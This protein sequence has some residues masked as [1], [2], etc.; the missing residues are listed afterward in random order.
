VLAGLAAG[1]GLGLILRRSPPPVFVRDL[2]PTAAVNWPLPRDPWG[3]TIRNPYHVIS[4]NGEESPHGIGMHPSFDGPANLTYALNKQYKRFM[5]RVSLNDTVFD[6][7]ASPMTFTVYGD[8]EVLWRSDPVWTRRETQECD[9]SVQGVDKLTL[10]V[11]AS[12]KAHG[13]H[14]VWIEPRL[15]K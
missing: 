14:G 15:M 3:R 5:A 10:E 2:K 12:A 4:V 11:S 7:S 1:L 8:G 13:A 6:R 9:I